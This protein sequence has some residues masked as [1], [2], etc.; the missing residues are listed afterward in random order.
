MELLLRGQVK[1]AEVFT[2]KARLLELIRPLRDAGS[3]VVLEKDEEHGVFEIVLQQPVNG[4]TREVRRRATSFVALA[5]V[6]GALLRPTRSSASWTARRW[7]SSTA[8]RRRWADREA[9]LDHILAEGKRGLSIQ[10]YKGLGEMNAEEL[11][12]PP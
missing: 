1:D 9:L 11:G 4:H 8:A 2:D 3:D 10:R 7:S 5:R 12:R 6:Q